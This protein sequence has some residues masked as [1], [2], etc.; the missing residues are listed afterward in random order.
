[1]ANILWVARG[2][3]FG[4]SAHFQKLSLLTL[5]ITLVTLPLM[6]AGIQWGL[7]GVF[8]RINYAAQVI[9]L[10]GLALQLLKLQRTK[11]LLLEER[12]N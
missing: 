3:R 12:F 2:K 10:M 9:W 7:F 4:I 5:I 8:Q 6:G 11:L 1:M